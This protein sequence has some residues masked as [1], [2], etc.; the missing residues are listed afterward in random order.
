[1]D[2]VFITDHVPSRLEEL[3]SDRL[4]ASHEPPVT[5]GS[6]ILLKL[7]RKYFRCGLVGGW[8]QKFQAV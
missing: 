1:M 5:P 8:K 4:P 2:A 6:V 3:G 7:N